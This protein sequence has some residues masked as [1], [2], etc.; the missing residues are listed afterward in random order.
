MTV[1]APACGKNGD[2]KFLLQEQTSFTLLHPAE[3]DPGGYDCSLYTSGLKNSM[4]KWSV[5]DSHQRPVSDTD[6]SCRIIINSLKVWIPTETNPAIKKCLEM[7]Y[8]LMGLNR[9]MLFWVSVHVWLS[10]ECT[11]QKSCWRN[12]V[13][14]LTTHSHWARNCFWFAEEENCQETSRISVILFVNFSGKIACPLRY[15]VMWK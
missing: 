1:W 4:F 15:F 3:E 12:A 11:K 10:G 6:C 8:L 2:E 14:F 9:L 5:S 13:N 7:T